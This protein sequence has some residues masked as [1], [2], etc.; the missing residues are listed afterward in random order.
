MKE[1][2]ISRVP[3][4]A[5]LPH[6][7]IHYLAESLLPREVEAGELILREG[8]SEDRFFIL[9]DGQVEVIRGLGTEGERMLGVRES[10][11]VIGEMSLFSLDGRHT[12]SVRALTP[13]QLLEMTRSDFD[14]LL[15]RQPSMAY[16]MVRTLSTRLDESENL[17][18]RDVMEKNRELTK[19]Y[20][21]LQAAQAQIIEKEKLEAELQVA[22]TIQRSILP[23][24]H[25]HIA[26]FDIGTRVEAMRSVGGDFYDFIQL[27]NNRL[28]IVVGDVTDHGIPA[29]I[30]MALTYSVLRAEA[31]RTQTTSAALHNVN[32]V[33]ID[34]NESCMFATV[35][36]GILD[37]TTR[38]FTFVR[39]GHDL[40]ILLNAQG[41]VISLKESAGQL[42]GVIPAL[43]LE[44]QTVALE[45]G[46]L[47]LMYTDG[48][49]EAFDADE[50]QFG[51]ER[52]EETV[53]HTYHISAQAVCD[54]VWEAVKTFSGTPAPHD[55]VTLVAVRLM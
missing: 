25:P 19:A 31:I 3:L 8:E 50:N 22:R 5:S 12:A 44:E 37:C 38:E 9:L 2:I 55:D 53:Q 34:M 51:R 16:E 36:Y 15:Q 45:P 42:L 39:A 26:G 11:S 18:I 35:L 1:H 48:I 49:T 52:L 46:S 17:T 24:E 30:F 21:E 29:A 47:I 14:Q 41:E 32:D 40:P 10:G 43:V 33:L 28:G 27:E 4:F 20:N 6:S 23:S 54:A 7:E 13:L